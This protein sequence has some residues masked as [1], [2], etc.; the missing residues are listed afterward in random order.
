M[1]SRIVAGSPTEQNMCHLI[2]VWCC[3]YQ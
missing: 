3:A 1:T 2:P